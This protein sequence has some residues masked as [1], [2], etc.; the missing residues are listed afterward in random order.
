M[1]E[2]RC[3]GLVGGLGPAATV[4]YYRA[5]L[6][7]HAARGRVARML[8]AHADVDRVLALAGANE[9]DG[10]ARYLAGIIASLQAGG[11]ELAAMVAITPHLCMPQLA[12][13]S[14]LPIVDMVTEVVRALR[15]RGLGRVAL[16]GTRSTV[17]TSMFGQLGAIEVAMP[18]PDEVTRIHDSYL[19]L[20][21]GRHTPAQLDELRTLART[22]ITRDGVQAILLAG[23]DLSTVFDEANAGFPLIDCAG[24]HVAAIAKRL[25]D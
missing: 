4:Y 18:R 10:L 5:L 15:A 3:L 1:T 9:R 8:I 24:V 22:L 23:T 14:P 7:A 6:A 17:E 21:A 20:V 16:F 12:P 13:L 2:T 19:D 11:A 25:L